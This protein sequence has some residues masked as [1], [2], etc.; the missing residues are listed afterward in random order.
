MVPYKPGIKTTEFWIALIIC[1]A[2]SI[3]GGLIAIFPNE[4]WVQVASVVVGGF[5]TTFTAMGYIKER[6]KVKT[7]P[8]EKK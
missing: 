6:G 8:K 3:V 1:I 2:W 5:V 7:T 4:T